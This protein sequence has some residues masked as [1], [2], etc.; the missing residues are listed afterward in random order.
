MPA[1]LLLFGTLLWVNSNF[2]AIVEHGV[3]LRV[4]LDVKFDGVAF[5]SALDTEIEPLGVPFRVDVVLHEAV[6]FLIGNFLSQEKITW[7]ESRFKRQ[8]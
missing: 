4:I 5:F 2:H 7:F 8:R 1:N 6:I 3:A